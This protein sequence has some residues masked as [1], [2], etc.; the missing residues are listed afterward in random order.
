[1]IV[2]QNPDGTLS[3][4][5]N[6]IKK[7]IV[8]FIRE[9]DEP[10]VY[11]LK[12]KGE[13]KGAARAFG[14]DAVGVTTADPFY[15]LEPK[16]KAY[17]EKGYD[18]G[19]EKGTIAEKVDPRATMPWA[20]SI[21]AVAM[22]YPT[23]LDRA[24]R[25]EQGAYRGFVAR[26]AWGDDYHVV[27]RERLLL[28]AGWLKDRVPDV[29]YEVMVDTGV[30]SDRAVAERAG[31]GWI[32]KNGLLITPEYGSFVYLGE[33]VVSVTLPPDQPMVE[34]CGSCRKCLDLCPTQAFE[35]PG[36]LNGK[37]CL[38]YHTQTK[39][40][41]PLYF[42]E[43]MGNRL[44]GCD[45]CQLV[46][47]YN[48]GQN[49]THHERF[50]PDPELV[51]P[52]LMPL[53]GMSKKTFQNTWAKSAAGWRGKKTIERNAI[54]A[55]GHYRSKEATALLTDRMF[56]DPRPVIRGTA[57]WALGKIGGEEVRV[58]LEKARETER[59]ADVLEE[60]EH[61][62]LICNNQRDF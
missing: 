7:D 34:Q 5:N 45:T 22:A 43:K 26:S 55:L 53:V 33:L 6:T 42:R 46:C 52:L 23:R 21:I 3:T 11:A 32:G 60:I 13:M 50:R 9:D 44:Y 20:K 36:V 54:I 12:L 51:K 38:S 15:E 39:G 31:I 19:F 62:F 41:V 4:K 14:L 16:L 49:W 24:P 1:M 27:L 40:F 29:R 8:P 18:T 61:A 35:A 47:P 56:H 37:R 2:H 17:Y 48:R 30:L 59:D 57:A 25:S 28:L 10:E 58:A